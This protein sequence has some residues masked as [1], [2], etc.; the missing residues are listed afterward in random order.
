MTLYNSFG[1]KGLR[2]TGRGTIRRVLEKNEAGQYYL[3]EQ[4]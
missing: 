1:V 2:G 4:C 3:S